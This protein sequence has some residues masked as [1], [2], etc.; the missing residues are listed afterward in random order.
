MRFTVFTSALMGGLVSMAFAQAVVDPFLGEPF[1]AEFY[2][3]GDNNQYRATLVSY[4]FGAS[5]KSAPQDSAVVQ[6]ST[7]APQDS[8]NGTVN[9]PKAAVLYIH[10]FN[11]YY[12]QT[13]TAEKL[14]SA[15]YAFF[16]ID[17]HNYGRSY[18]QGEVLGELR[19]V[20]SYFP[21][22]DSAW[23]KIEAAVG[24]DVPKVLLGHSTGGLVSL[25]F[26]D[27][28]E[29]G[30]DFDAIVLNS[31]FMEMNYS[32]LMRDVII[33]VLA[34]IGHYFPNIPIPRSSSDAYS[35]SL[36]KSMK[37]EWEYN[38]TLKVPGSIPVDFGW[39]AAI[40]DA[41]DIVKAGMDLVSPIL[42]MHSGCSV[43]E[44]EWS[45]EYT[46]CDG[47]LNVDDIRNYGAHLGPDVR[48]VQIP[49]ALHDLYLSRK[50]V[51]DHAYSVTIEFLDNIVKK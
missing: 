3:A 23:K 50:E 17:L 15:G 46:R 5:G 38:T 40:C 39:S 22:I 20:T 12:F 10:G 51:R 25:V 26:A 2:D 14:D 30:K 48:L 29:K 36:L 34:P 6:D 8:L 21:E 41:Q 49:G 35:E 31:P 47:V 43:N 9:K 37:G 13:L 28:R 19:D 44:D 24:K 18:R 33:P 32:W 27:V 42:V 1:T 7:A 4:P 11:D 45:D 16:A